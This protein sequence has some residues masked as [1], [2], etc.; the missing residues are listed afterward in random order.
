MIQALPDAASVVVIGG[1]IVG[2]STAYHLAKRGRRDVLL[3]ERSKLTS[4]TTWHSA[5]MVRQLRS[6]AAL[7]RL[8]NYSA[9]LY[10]SLEEETGQSTGWIGCGSLSIAANDDRMTHIRRQASLARAFGIEVE[11][12]DA[13]EIARLWPIANT[14]DLVGGILSPSDGR[15]S[16]SDACAALV[17]G[18]R[19]G[20]VTIVEDMPVT[21]FRVANGRVTGVETAVG[22]VACEAVALTGGL[23]SRE[24]ARKAGVSA[25][26]YACEHFAV[27]TKPFDGI[28]PGMP[29]LGA[30]DGHMYIRDEGQGL[31][32]GCF[33]PHARPVDLDALPKDFSFD[34]LDED[35]EHMEPIMEEALHRIPALETAEVRVLLNGPESFTLDGA[36]LM[37]EAPELGGF[38]MCCGMNS[39]GVASSGG[40]GRA[41]ADWVVDGDPGLDL[42]SVDV[43][44]FPR[45]RDS[46]RAVRDRAAENLA[47]HYAVGYPGREFDTGRRLRLSPLHERLADLGAEFGDRGGWERPSWFQPSGGGVPTDLRFGKPHWFDCVAR[48]HHAARDS[49]AVFDQ[50]S[51]SKILVQGRD[52]ARF[53]DRACAGRVDAPV[54]RV[55]YTP[56][57]NERGGYESDMV[58]MRLAEEVFLIV[59]GSAQQARDID[60]LRRRI[61]PSDFVTLTDVT[62][63]YAV[64]GVMGPKSRTLL[65][66]L[67]KEALDNEAFPYLAHREIEIA[68]TV[69]RA[70]RISYVGELGW[71]LYV[72]TEAGLP[73]YDAIWEAGG[74]LGLEN[75]GSFAMTGLRIEKGYCAWGHDIGPDDTPLQAGL[76]FSVRRDGDFVGR[77]ALARQREAGLD[78][79]RV[80]LAV[81]DPDVMLM[82]SE[83]IVVD[84]E[85]RGY[86]T[87]AAYGHTA[88]RSVAMG[89][90]DLKGDPLDEILERG[91]F[92]IEVALER[93]AAR[94]SLR[95]FHDPDGTRLRV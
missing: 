58:V 73:L 2:C 30:H 67:T 26:L 14:D 19:A 23:W 38:F 44:R 60:T 52:A 32:V 46:L 18:A 13:A 27:I 75:A 64:I 68:G 15:I 87:S 86:T 16:A 25:P 88:G 56:I 29:I 31:L 45:V 89:Y 63:A 91:R 71:E 85:I 37:G 81:E 20:G 53:L 43:R 50:T 21:G 11:E 95:A 90:V 4:G 41:L 17:K 51:F 35:W 65:Q 48:E 6:T 74:D 22:T 1:G 7:T 70:A 93:F 8:M 92:E 72:P 66:R 34:L 40:A 79:R 36:F 69:A 78:R 61:G 83:P 77:A 49:V 9:S 82:G 3:L 76:G 84:G 5:A 24:L 80:L 94:A 55:V 59:T 62:S 57:L 12:I 42:S 28:Y 47:I 54:G 33:E 10:Q 39:M